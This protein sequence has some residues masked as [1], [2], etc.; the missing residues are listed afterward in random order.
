VELI[1]DKVEKLFID[2]H[3]KQISYISFNGI[4]V[5]PQSVFLQQ[6]IQWPVENQR[7][8]QNIVFL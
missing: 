1:K 6:R 2:F 7:I 4:A 8:G 3:V 5:K